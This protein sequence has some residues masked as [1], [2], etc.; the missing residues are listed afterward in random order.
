MST[1][2]L[3]NLGV[4]VAIAGIIFYLGEE[5]TTLVLLAITGLVYLYFFGMGGG[6]VFA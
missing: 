2:G 4:A 1:R 5:N 6:K 3:I